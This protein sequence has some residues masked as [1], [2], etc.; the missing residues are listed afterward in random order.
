MRE[1]N[2]LYKAVLT[3]NEWLG[4]ENS[5]SHV[6]IYETVGNK[7]VVYYNIART[8]KLLKCDPN[9]NPKE[10]LDIYSFVYDFWTS[11]LFDPLSD[12]YENI[13]MENKS[14]AYKIS[15]FIK[16][17]VYLKTDMLHLQGYEPIKFNVNQFD[18]FVEPLEDKT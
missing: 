17:E 18:G 8:T 9:M 5:V 12:C 10:R 7:R 15:Q 13:S 4:P 11:N 6:T 14:N 2:I 1:I 16:S 3:I